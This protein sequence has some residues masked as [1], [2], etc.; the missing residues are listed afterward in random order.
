MND[1]S[2]APQCAEHLAAFVERLKVLR[3]SPATL[4]CREHSL[5]RFFQWLG[6]RHG[7]ARARSRSSKD[8]SLALGNFSCL[9]MNCAE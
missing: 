2:L 5:R 9:F 6:D 7:L 4:V 1:T 3:Y 8:R